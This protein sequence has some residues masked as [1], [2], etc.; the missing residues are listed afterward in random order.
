V[1]LIERLK[2]LAAE[3]KLSVPDHFNKECVLPNGKDSWAVKA[4]KIRAYGWY[5]DALKG[6][7]MVSH[8]AYKRGAKMA[9]ADKNKV[10]ANWRSFENNGK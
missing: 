3:A 8:F 4:S 10:I 1:A 7:F 9:R 6:T 2:R 5:S